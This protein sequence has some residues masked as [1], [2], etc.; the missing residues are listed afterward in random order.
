MWE[1]QMVADTKAKG[2][3]VLREKVLRMALLLADFLTNTPVN[4][5]ITSHVR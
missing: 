4:L 1:L 2:N 5:S 3:P